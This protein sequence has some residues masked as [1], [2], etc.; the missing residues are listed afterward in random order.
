M[1]F[2]FLIFGTLTEEKE[3]F[4]DFLLPSFFKRKDKHV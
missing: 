2:M 3:D 4:L 1:Q